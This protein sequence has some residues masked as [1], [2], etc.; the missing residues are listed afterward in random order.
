MCH[1]ALMSYLISCH[2]LSSKDKP[3]MTF[4]SENIHFDVIRELNFLEENLAS[5][6]FFIF[7]IQKGINHL[8]ATPVQNSSN[9]SALILH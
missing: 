2:I 8:S 9:S 3:L 4:S 6:V 1:S 7:H 5:D